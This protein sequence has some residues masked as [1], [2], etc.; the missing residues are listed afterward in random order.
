MRVEFRCE[1]VPDSI[2]AWVSEQRGEIGH[3]DVCVLCRESE[4]DEDD[5]I[6]HDVDPGADLL[7]RQLPV[8]PAAV[9][10]LIDIGAARFR[11]QTQDDVAKSGDGSRIAPLRPPCCPSK[12][13]Y[14]RSE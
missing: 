3:L 12:L 2:V 11:R 8:R 4:E 9:V 1:R 5:P 14:N 7:K 13:L 6:A 10:E